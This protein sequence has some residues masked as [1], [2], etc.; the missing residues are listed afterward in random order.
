MNYAH[1]NG[2][3]SAGA[4]NATRHLD[5]SALLPPLALAAVV[6]ISSTPVLASASG[7]N[8]H[9]GNFPGIVNADGFY[10]NVKAPDHTVASGV[11]ALTHTRAY[12]NMAAGHF[13]GVGVMSFDSQSNR[14]LT[15]QVSDGNG[16][17]T[18]T[19]SS[20]VYE[21]YDAYGNK[22]VI[23]AGMWRSSGNTW[24]MNWWGP[25]LNVGVDAYNSSGAYGPTEA[26]L[27][28]DGWGGCGSFYPI[29]TAWNW[30]Y[31]SGAY[32]YYF[33]STNNYQWGSTPTWFVSGNAANGGAIDF[34]TVS[35]P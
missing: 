13:L 28:A 15:Y 7:T 27:G 26:S 24:H 22:N 5:G 29:R 3:S 12:V 18:Y 9:T 32:W 10:F 17:Y 23:S 11:R 4:G 2:E 8:S 14:R 25:N 21:P 6:L 33:P 35:C 1:K 31:R 19:L 20:P 34:G 30:L 16:F